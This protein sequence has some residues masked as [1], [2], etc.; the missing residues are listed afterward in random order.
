MNLNNTGITLAR[1]AFTLVTGRAAT[2]VDALERQ[3][4]R[5]SGL[6]DLLLA[7]QMGVAA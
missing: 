6:P 5:S 2:F 4:R 1:S 7:K 3:T